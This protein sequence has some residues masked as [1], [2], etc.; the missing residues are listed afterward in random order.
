M[1]Y[2][3]ITKDFKILTSY[4][5]LIGLTLLLLNDFLF[6]EL[7]GNWITGKL[8]DFAGLFIFP[9]FWTA[10]LPKHKNKIFVITGIL[11]IYWKSAYSQEI[12]DIWNS[13][14][15][16]DVARTVDYTDL[17]ALSVL[18]FAFFIHKEKDRI[19]K[20]NISPVFPLIISLFAFTAT[21][22]QRDYNYNTTYE[23]S[24]SKNELLRKINLLRNDSISNNPPLSLNISNANHLIIDNSDTLWYFSSESKIINDTVWK[25]KKIFKPHKNGLYQAKKTNEVDT[26]YRIESKITDTMYVDIEGIFI[27]YI[28]SEKYMKE[29]KTGYCQTVKTKVKL[30]GTEASSSLTLLTIYTENCM[31][32][33]EKDAQTNEKDNLLNAFE[34]EFI[35]KIKSIP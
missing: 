26:V 19:R 15:L 1:A 34:T 30:D 29:S 35:D 7:F 16:F 10:L 4:Y 5:F 2:S 8:S 33:F 32:M 14:G 27:H 17:I 22:Y 28:P 11:F 23:F 12:I 13:F 9:L 24:F 20:F 6:K 21:S 3:K 18:P 25:Y 31:G